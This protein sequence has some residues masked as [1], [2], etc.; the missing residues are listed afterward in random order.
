[1]IREIRTPKALSKIACAEREKSEKEYNVNRLL[2]ALETYLILKSESH[3]I[4]HYTK[5]LPYLLELCK[6]SRQ[7]FYNRIE[8]C[9]NYGLIIKEGKNLLLVSWKKLSDILL[10]DLKQGFTTIKY[11]T[12]RKLPRLRY[13]ITQNEFTENQERQIYAINKRLTAHSDNKEAFTRLCEEYGYKSDFTF[14]NYEQAKRIAFSKG[15][16][17]GDYELL[18]ELNLSTSRNVYTIATAHGYTHPQ[19]ASYIKKILSE[20]GLLEVV[21]LAPAICKYK[22]K[23]EKHTKKGATKFGRFYH[24]GIQTA[25]MFQPDTIIAKNPVFT[26]VQENSQTQNAPAKTPSV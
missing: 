10:I 13:L 12:D 8:A 23:P 14:E 3:K 26:D 16:E 11:D 6:I 18:H 25:Y 5:Q 19:G 4:H 1:M 24:K 22:G 17:S 2:P 7:T 9:I 20:M 21:K 15:T